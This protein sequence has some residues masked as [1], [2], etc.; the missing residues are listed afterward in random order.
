M[1]FKFI[2]GGDEVKLPIISKSL[3]FFICTYMNEHA[4]IKIYPLHNA[5][6]S[7]NAQDKR[8]CFRCSGAKSTYSAN[9]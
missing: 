1:V 9:H 5:L 3:N 8:G 4:Q 7:C 6:L 2:D